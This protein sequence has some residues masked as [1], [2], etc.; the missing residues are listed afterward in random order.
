MNDIC[1]ISKITPF[2][3]LDWRG[4]SFRRADALRY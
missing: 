2:Q 1:G 3:G 4:D